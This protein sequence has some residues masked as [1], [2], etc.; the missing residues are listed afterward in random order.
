MHNHNYYVIKLPF[1][2]LWHYV[3][4][5][6]LV[7]HG[8]CIMGHGSLSA[9]VTGSWVNASDPLPALGTRSGV[10][11]VISESLFF[12]LFD[13]YFVT[14]YW[15]NLQC[16]RWLINQQWVTSDVSNDYRGYKSRGWTSKMDAL[17][18]TRTR[19]YRCNIIAW[20]V[21][22]TRHSCRQSK[23]PRGRAN[24]INNSTRPVLH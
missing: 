15:Q 22:G 7:G 3:L 6:L 9:W 8:S 21:P 17:I 13:A 19:V 11:V 24:M 1:T 20:Y 12:E 2:A 18:I 4:M 16:V 23:E 5:R 10:I 14:H